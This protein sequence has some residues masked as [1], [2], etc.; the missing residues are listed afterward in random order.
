MGKKS[1]ALVGSACALLAEFGRNIKLAV[2][3][4]VSPTLP[5]TS[6]QNA[7]GLPGLTKPEKQTI[8]SAHTPGGMAITMLPLEPAVAIG[9]TIA[10]AWTL[11]YPLCA[12]R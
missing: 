8:R 9:A 3:G 7:I 5:K 10:L 2:L 4:P 12:S 1:T 11:E 6:V